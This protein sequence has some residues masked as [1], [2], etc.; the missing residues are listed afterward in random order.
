MEFRSLRFAPVPFDTL[1][2]NLF[3]FSG[4]IPFKKAS[5]E[6]FFLNCRIFNEYF[7]AAAHSL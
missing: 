4:V 6:A 5:R 3:H 1:V 7:K 2:I